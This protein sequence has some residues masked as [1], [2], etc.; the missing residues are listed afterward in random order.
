MKQTPKYDFMSFVFATTMFLRLLSV[1][2]LNLLYNAKYANILNWSMLGLASSLNSNWIFVPQ[3]RSYSVPFGWVEIFSNR[4]MTPV[5]IISWLLWT[6]FM[7]PDWR[8][9]AFFNSSPKTIELQFHFKLFPGYC[10]RL[11]IQGSHAQHDNICCQSEFHYKRRRWK[12]LCR[13]WLQ[14]NGRNWWILKRLMWEDF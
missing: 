1:K 8:R 11:S 12:N 4:Q 14:R 3:L 5:S 2:F 13:R 7:K 9:Q 6:S 10:R